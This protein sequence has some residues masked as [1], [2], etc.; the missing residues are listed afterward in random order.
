MSINRNFYK[1]AVLSILA[2]LLP[3]SNSHAANPESVVAQVA[4]VAPI[5]VTEV[6][7]LQYGLISTAMVS[8]NTVIVPPTGAYTDATARVIGGT[9]AAAN[10]TV[11]ATASEALTVLVDN[12][13][14][15]TGYALSAFQCKYDTDAAGNCDGAGLSVAVSSASVTLLVGATMTGDG[16]QSSGDADGSFDVTVSYQ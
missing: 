11:T 15:G 10:L 8:G 6:S 4:F 16:L 5:T 2:G 12:I 13:V 1:G 7:A 14:D 9:Q 3:L